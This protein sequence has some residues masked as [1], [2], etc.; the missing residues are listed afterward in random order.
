MSAAPSSARSP[1]S[2]RSAILNHDARRTDRPLLAQYATWISGILAAG[3]HGHVL[4]LSARRSRPSSSTPRAIPHEAGRRRLPAGRA[5]R[6]SRRRHCRR[7]DLAQAQR[8]TGPG[9][10]RWMLSATVD[11][12]IRH[13]HRP[14]PDLRRLAALAADLGGA[15]QRCRLLHPAL[16]SDPAVAAAGVLVLFG[17]IARM[18]RCRHDRGARSRLYQNGGPQGP[19][20]A[21]RSSG[22][23]CCAT[24]CLPT[25]TVIATQTGLSSSAAS[26]SS[27]SLF[28]YQG[29]GSA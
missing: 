4:R 26:S 9:R 19:D 5:A 28:R 13:R 17:Y 3:D 25:I 11:A 16:P 6:H 27:R 8:R 12:G 29:I 14:D 18:A 1:T 2:A 20:P 7:S 21:A 22:A 23:M 15:A 10:R 24:R